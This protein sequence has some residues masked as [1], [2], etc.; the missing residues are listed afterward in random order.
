M[1][2]TKKQFDER[3]KANG[4][5]FQELLSKLREISTTP[6]K[7]HKAEAVNPGVK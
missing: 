6:N 3:V 1:D 2:L 5:Y 7:A 4:K